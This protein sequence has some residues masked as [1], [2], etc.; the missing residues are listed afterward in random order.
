LEE[1]KRNLKHGQPEKSTVAYHSIS[2][3][4]PICWENTKVLCHEK[5]YWERLTK[6]ANEIRM[7]KNI[8]RD[9]GYSLSNTWKPAIR[10]I[11]ETREKR[12]ENSEQSGDT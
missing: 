2:H 5:K 9:G 4:H 3:D 8:N 11:R 12:R 6:E 1:H 7:K 10:R